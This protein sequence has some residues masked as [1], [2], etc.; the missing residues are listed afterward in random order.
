MAGRINLLL[1]FRSNLRGV[2]E[3]GKEV[4]K[5]TGKLTRMAK[6]GVGIGAILGVGAGGVGI[7]QALGTVREY[8]DAMA[9]VEAVTRATKGEMDAMKVTARELGSTTA[10]SAGQAGSAMGFLGMAGFESQEIISAIPGVLSLAAAGNLDLA[11]TADIASNILSGFNMEAS[12]TNRVVDV[13]AAVSSRANTD[14]LEMGEAM[15]F[16]APSSDLLAVT[17]E[18]S[19]AAIGILSN[20]GL[21]ATVAGTGLNRV[22][23]DLITPSAEAKKAIESL[24]LTT[25][26]VNPALNSLD[27]ILQRFADSNMGAAEAAIIFGKQG[28]GPA[29]TLIKAQAIGA[30]QDL[31]EELENSQGAA[32]RMADIR[33]N[34]LT[35]DIRKLESAFS[36]L[37]LKLFVDFGLIDGVRELITGTSQL[38]TKLGESQTAMITMQSTV[39]M[40]ANSV[41]DLG[42]GILGTVMIIEKVNDRLRLFKFGMTEAE[43]EV[44]KSK[45][46]ENPFTGLK[47]DINEVIEEL[48]SFYN[49][50]KEAGPVEKEA[51]SAKKL[52]DEL[53]RVKENL[54]TMTGT[55]DGSNSKGSGEEGS[56][57]TPSKSLLQSQYQESYIGL[58]DPLKHYQT[59]GEGALGGML[60]VY[61]EIGTVG[62]QIYRQTLEIADAMRN[63]IGT[64]IQGLLQGTMTWGQALMNVGQSIV[65]GLVQSFSRMVADFIMQQLIMRSAMAMTAQFGIGVEAQKAA[66]TN[67]IA[68]G[69]TGILA[70]NATLASIGSFG[71]AVG[72]GLAAMA[73]ITAA[74]GGFK[75]G[76][77]TGDGSPSA[78]AGVAH[79]REYYFTAQDVDAI[80]KNRIEQFRFSRGM[81]GW[82]QPTR[83]AASAMPGTSAPSGRSS[84]GTYVYFDRRQMIKDM[85]SRDGDAMVIDAFNRNRVGLGV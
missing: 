55:T 5:L 12:E 31:T 65:N 63:G 72:I 48:T 9:G 10:F 52:N 15:K 54:G 27:E 68:A 75:E 85:Q 42:I 74:M 7:T 58:T 1:N 35:G 43:F 64:S 79:K 20:S 80:G 44:A 70:A 2:E 26:E 66:A 34:T 59:G 6:M 39:V 78:V 67:A 19:A 73:G 84:G 13:L 30:L 4:S 38:A 81:A 28:I 25:D 83:I 18:E 14:V 32:K 46:W 40:L 69:Q 49:F 45:K 62:D 61:N 51:E 77:Y 11:Q 23:L 36:E 33:M 82:A 41:K 29:T 53:K 3:A 24:G 21:K 60:N 50:E 16:A 56:K 47:D 37:A 71:V 17:V 8:E 22:L 76:G 57:L